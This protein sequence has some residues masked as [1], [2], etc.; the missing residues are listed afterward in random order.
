MQ[1]MSR[2]V[3][4]ERFPEFRI[5][6]STKVPGDR[7]A[8]YLM[9]RS[10][11]ES[12]PDIIRTVIERSSQSATFT[13]LIKTPVISDRCCT[14]RMWLDKGSKDG[15]LVIHFASLGEWPK[16]KP[17]ASCVPVRAHGT[18]S[19][20]PVSAGTELTYTVFADPGGHLPVFLVRGMI[21]DDALDRVRKLIADLAE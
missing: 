19:F 9:G 4:G 1:V 12:E 14:T 20:K 15:E 3:E 5:Q 17:T 6:T 2:S 8:A 10:I 11:D 18:W 16:G 13:D 7:L 21:E